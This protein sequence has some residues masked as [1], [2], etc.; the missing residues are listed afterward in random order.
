MSL[1]REERLQ[2]LVSCQEA[3]FNLRGE[4]A[5]RSHFPSYFGHSAFRLA[6]SRQRIADEHIH[7]AAAAIK[8]RDQNRPSR[9]FANF[10]DDASLIAPRRFLQRL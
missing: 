1:T 6:D 10:A 4:L 7:D 2:Y 3:L 8:R 9:L 5:I